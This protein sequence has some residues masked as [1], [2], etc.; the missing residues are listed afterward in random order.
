MSQE[1]E[2]MVFLKPASL[3]FVLG[4]GMVFLYVA[5]NSYG[6]LALKDQIQKLGQ[7]QFTGLRSYCSY[8]FALFSSWRTWV[9]VGAICAATG[10]WII[11]L[12]HL[13]LSKAYP[14]AIGLNLLIVVGLSLLAY[15]EPFTVSKVA[16]VV[17]IIAGVVALFR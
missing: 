17:L 2:Q 8:F 15:Q 9:S 16:G 14:V 12:A 1:K 11:A 3:P 13:E 5:L 4:W 7:W 6:A 10:A